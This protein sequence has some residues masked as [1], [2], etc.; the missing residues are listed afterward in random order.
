MPEV[1]DLVSISITLESQ[2]ATRAGFGTLLIAGDSDKLPTKDVVVLTFDAQLV[3]SNSIAGNVDGV[4]I[5][6]V[7][8]NTNHDTTIADLI[9]ELLLASGIGTAVASDVGAVGYDNTVTCTATNID[10]VL[11]LDSFVVTLGASQPTITIVRTPFRRTKTYT[12]L[13]EV[14]VDFA[15]T[16]PEYKA[17]S[18]FFS[19]TPNPGTLKIG[20]IDSGNDWSDELT[21]IEAIDNDWYGLVITDRTIVD[22]T[23]VAAW[24]KTRTK[25]FAIGTAD[26]NVLNSGV[27]TDM[28]SVIQTAENDRA[29]VLYNENAGTTYPEAAWMADGFSRD[30]GSQT[31]MYKTLVGV[32]ASPSITTAQRAAAFAKNANLYESYGGSDITRNGNVGFS[33]VTGAEFID[34]TRSVDWLESDMASRIFTLLASSPKVA[35]TNEGLGAIEGQIRASLDIAIKNNVL[36][37]DPDSYSGQDYRVTRSDVND[38]SAAERAAR[39]VPAGAITFDSKLAGAVHTVAITGVVA[40]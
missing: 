19:Q 3:A 24:V 40:I 4:A 28:A 35:Y 21:L 7:V 31:W 26:A 25:L 5:T 11:T 14:A 32:T 20:R 23:D 6:P 12:T 34:V 16:D 15:T 38:I 13:A 33:S 27:S 1:S 18:A 2:A 36:R 39:N 9:T 10:T 29:F 17:A 37:A 8:F 22:Q 30:P